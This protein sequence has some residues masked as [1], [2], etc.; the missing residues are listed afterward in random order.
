MQ[1]VAVKDGT[2]TIAVNGRFDLCTIPLVEADLSTAFGTGCTKIVLDFADTTY[3]DSASISLLIKLKRR[4][5]G[6]NISAKNLKGEVYKVF[7]ATNL[8]EDFHVDA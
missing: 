5:G 4:V 3:I 6:E 8:L 7:E 2:A 1:Y